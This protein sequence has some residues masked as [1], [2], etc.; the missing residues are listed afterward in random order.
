MIEPF[1]LAAARRM[2]WAFHWGVPPDAELVVRGAGLP[3]VIAQLGALVWIELDDG[4]ELHPDGDVL[5]A[6]SRFGTDLFLVAETGVIGEFTPGRIEA[7]GYDTNKGR[8]EEDTWRHA[9]EAPHPWLGL[10][11]HG[12]PVVERRDSQFAVTWRGIVR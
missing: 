7:I 9:F 12:R 1:D 6:T 5:L 11:A 3:D 8:A 2:Y 4:R 10:D